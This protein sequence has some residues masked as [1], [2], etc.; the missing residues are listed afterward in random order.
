[1]RFDFD[2]T[3]IGSVPFRDAKASCRI[4]FENFKSIPFWPQLPRRTFLENM[5]AQYS[6]RM[7]G[8]VLDEE[9]KTVHIDTSRVIDDIERLYERYIDGD[10]E[11]FRISEDR[12]RGLYEFLK[13]MRLM[14]D[15]SAVKFVKGHL[16]GPVSFA[17]SVTD[18][19]KRPVIY[20]KDLFE[21]VTKVL[22]MKA[23]WQIKKLKEVFREVIIF[24]DEPYL[25]SIGSSYVNINME[26]AARKL[27]EV[28][29]AVRKEGALSG[30]HCCGN[31]DWPFI[32]KRNIDVLSFDAYNFMK[33]FSL[34]AAEIKSFLASG[35][36]IAW[37][38]VPS[39][40]AV[41]K[42]T[43]ES[44]AGRLKDALALL[45]AKGIDKDAV[46]SLVTPS[47]GVGSLD[48]ETATKV[49]KM[50]RALSAAL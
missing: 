44:V 38:I 28:I 21:V 16:T 24:I 26:D 2:A 12:A 22:A 20:D 32:L 50:T 34:Y 37:G 25:V 35:G 5:Y 33:E 49:L 3:G 17:L 10:L 40:D 6:E 42:E 8:L 19:N 7:P 31:T 46:P 43:R 11:F 39:S 9:K 36:A 27:D 45:A 29:E 4:I 47:C 23:R 41:D 15:K 48:E 30:I 13:S 18:Q 1:M 14:Q